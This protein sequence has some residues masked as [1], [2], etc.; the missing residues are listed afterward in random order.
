M[1]GNHTC[2]VTIC[3]TSEAVRLK[4]DN[5]LLLIGTN[6]LTSGTVVMLC[7]GTDYP[8]R[9]MERKLNAVATYP[10]AENSNARQSEICTST[11]NWKSDLILLKIFNV[12][13]DS[14]AI[15][16]DSKKPSDFPAHEV[17]KLEHTVKSL[18]PPRH[19]FSTHPRSRKFSHR[20]H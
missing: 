13:L 7:Y 10:A 14:K 12:C 20:F 11:V 4:R 18:C 1:A 17:S 3:Q 6:S 19:K 16:S 9:L 8:R 5:L 2:V 15:L